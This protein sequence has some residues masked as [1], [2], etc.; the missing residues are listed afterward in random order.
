MLDVGYNVGANSGSHRLHQYILMSVKTRQQA[1]FNIT[2][3]S[4]LPIRK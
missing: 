1:V 3:I 4:F 2:L